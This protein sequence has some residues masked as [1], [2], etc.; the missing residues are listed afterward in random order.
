MAPVATSSAAPASRRMSCCRGL[1]GAGGVV[2]TFSRPCR[3]PGSKFG[4]R[5]NPVRQRRQL[6]PVEAV[7]G[8]R[9]QVAELPDRREGDA[10][11]ALDRG[12]PLEPAQVE[13]YRLREPGQVVHAQDL[14]G[15]L[16]ARA[17]LGVLA[18]E[19]EHARIGGA[20]L[21]EPAEPEDRVPFPDLD[22]ALGPVQQG[23]AVLL[24]RLDVE[25]LEAVDRVHQQRQVE[26]G[27]DS[28]SAVNSCSWSRWLSSSGASLRRIPMLAFI[29]GSLAYSEYM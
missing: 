17:R 18:D 23:A 22:H 3:W 20:Q 12:D 16:R 7:P 19:R 6:E 4:G 11:H 27:R 9:Q 25:R 13:F 10:A 8:Q 21:L 28:S 24:L 15:A 26:P 29:L 1:P 5:L 14:V 2:M